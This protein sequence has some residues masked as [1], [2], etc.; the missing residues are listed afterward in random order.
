[1][2]CTSSLVADDVEHAQARDLLQPG[3]KGDFEATFSLGAV[4]GAGGFAQVRA[5]R[6]RDD[7]ENLAVKIVSV[8]TNKPGNINWMGQSSLQP[9]AVRKEKGEESD[10]AGEEG[11][12]Q[13]KTAPSA[14]MLMKE[15]V[16]ELASW[17]AV[18]GN[19]HVVNLVS[20]MVEEHR[21]FMVMERCESNIL[22][23]VSESPTFWALESRR[24][25]KEM[26]LGVQACHLAG[27]VHRDIKPQNYLLGSDGSTVK[28][29]DFGL[30]V[31]MPRRG[32]L[33]GVAGTIPFTSPEMLLDSGYGKA[34]DVWSY[35]VSAYYLCF[36]VF[37]FPKAFC[38]DTEC[39]EKAILLGLPARCLQNGSGE[40]AFIAPQLERGTSARCTVEQALAH[41]HLQE[42]TP[43]SPRAQKDGRS[44]CG[45]D[46]TT[47]VGTEQ[48]FERRASQTE[49]VGLEQENERK[50][51]QTE[52]TR[53]CCSTPSPLNGGD[54]P[55]CL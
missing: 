29:C 12:R 3:S 25:L 2:G 54:G 34:T 51:S 40:A 1:M 45:S 46:A 52:S 17:S 47:V 42:E 5:A 36:G 27:I 20:A 44:S 37:P 30:A 53:T 41:W 24:V 7:H 49:P 4:L 13:K 23:K 6:R 28:L 48:D 11:R 16:G 19:K 50:A 18:Q 26:L 32:Q 15:V 8:K 9:S 21:V 55:W 43:A 39:M 22:H 33:R 31:R 14:H 38:Q 10:E 35:G